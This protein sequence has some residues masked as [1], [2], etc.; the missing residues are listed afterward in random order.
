VALMVTAAAAATSS[1]GCLRPPIPALTAI[2]PATAYPRQ[3][4]AVDGDTLLASVVW[5]V[6]LPTEHVLSN[7]LFGTTYF[8]IPVN[9]PKGP[10]PVAI[11]TAGGTSTAVQ[12][13]VLEAPVKPFPAP[14]IED[15][16]I[17]GLSGSGPVDLALTVTA[18]NLDVD[19]VVTVRE[20][21]G[22]A[23]VSKNVPITV[24]WGGLPI[25]YQQDHQPDTFGYPIF[26]YTQLIS[27]VEGVTLGARLEVTVVNNGGQTAIGSY[28]LPAALDQIDSDGDALLD[29]WEVGEYKS[30][31]GAVPL[32]AMG[33]SPLRKDLL[34]E[35][36]WIADAAP[37]AAVW[38]AIE[39]VFAEA[40]ILNPDGSRGVNLVIDRGQGGALTNG[41]QVLADHD[42]VILGPLPAGA[43]AGCA[44]LKSFFGYKATHFDPARLNVVHYAIFGRQD[45]GGY[46]G[47]GER[48]GNDFFVA[49]LESGLPLDDVGIATGTFIHELGHNLG[50]SHEGP[51]AT[52]TPEFRFKPNLLSAVN[53]RYTA[54]GIPTDCDLLGDRVYTY[55]SGSLAALQ[56][57][58]MNESVGICDGVGA[59]LNGNGVID[60][61]G[62]LDLDGD[63]SAS[64]TWDDFNQW[65]ALR[66]DFTNGTGWNGN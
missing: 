53:Y 31:L 24:R 50:F 66:F 30:P 33:T 48:H 59:D 23:L 32:A 28:T 18:A 13:E 65:G 47:A 4:V 55:S 16:G 41:G 42:C 39:Q 57:A 36:D 45:I 1:G 52:G 35:V 11:R 6:G 27:I 8:Q 46:T 21:I 60:P 3:L 10:H 2:A 64:D 49:L 14:R 51:F 37:L 15:I 62:P 58:G 7:G 25:D 9:A 34:V 20:I 12:V 26:H 22:G 38:P 61:A 29:A 63:G 5:D 43:A 54:F 44:N 19:A 17:A 40:P 56:E